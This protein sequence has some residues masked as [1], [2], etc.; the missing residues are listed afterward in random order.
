MKNLIIIIFLIAF[1]GCATVFGGRKTEHQKHRPECGEEKRQIRVGALIANCLLFPPG[2]LIDLATH[3]FW[4]PEP[5]TEKI[6]ICEQTED[7]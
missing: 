1:T 5:N 6:K 3:K 7:K 4:K 2:I